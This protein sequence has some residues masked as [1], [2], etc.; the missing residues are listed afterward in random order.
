LEKGCIIQL[1]PKKHVNS[2]VPIWD[3]EPKYIYPP[4]LHLSLEETRSWIADQFINFPLSELSEEYVID[5]VI[6]WRLNKVSCHLIKSNTEWFESIIPTLKQFWNYVLFY[7]ENEDKLN[8]LE[9]FVEKVGISNSAE[10][11]NKIHQDFKETNKTKTKPLYQQPSEW[12]IKYNNKK[13]TFR[14]FSQCQ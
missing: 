14:K 7:R 2:D 1:L 5:K 9:E 10:I 11:F 6:Y 4:S 8:D 13:K 12:R 3:K